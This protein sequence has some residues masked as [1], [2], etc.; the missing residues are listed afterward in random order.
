MRFLLVA[1]SCI[2]HSSLFAQSSGTIT[3]NDVLRSYTYYVPTNL[4]N[5]PVPL[6]FVLH[7]TTQSGED[8]MDISNFNA[9]ADEN[10]FI[11]VY[12]DGINGFWNIGLAAGGS[13]ADDMGF[14]EALRNQFI[15]EYN[16]APMRIFS[17]GFSA[18]GYLSYKLACE[19]EYC[20]AAIASVAGLITESNFELC[21]P[22]NETSVLHIHGTSDFIVPYEGSAQAGLGVESILTYWIA[23]LS[24]PTTPVIEALP[25]TNTFDFST[26]EKQ[27]WSPCE[28]NFNR[29]VLLKIEGGGHQWPGT[30]ALLG[31][32]GTINRDISASEEIWTFFNEHACPTPFDAVQET[33]E[34]ISFFPNPTEN[35][36]TIS[37]PNDRSVSI[38]ITDTFGRIIKTVSASTNL[39][40]D[41][42]DLPSGMYYIHAEN[43]ISQRFLKL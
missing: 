13:S 28:N 35:T 1:L 25:N 37:L 18:G 34:A 36:L 16:I 11:V 42:Q 31:G 24:C 39:V 8:I 29:V 43:H 10:G 41:V 40:I 20:F 38:F 19:S 27:T 21:N 32:L 7:G 17:C 5:M 6:V 4:P 15:S 33:E 22:V 9:I 26:V 3:H 12:P 14:V 30:D 2:L 23:E